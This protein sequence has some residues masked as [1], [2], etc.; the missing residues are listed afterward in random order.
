MAKKSEAAKV[1]TANRLGDGLV[2]FLGKE[3]VW[4]ED[5]GKAKI[6]H[7]GEDADALLQQGINAEK[8]NHVVEPYLIDVGDDEAAVTPLHIRE[9]IRTLGPSVRL[10]LGK[11]AA[12][13]LF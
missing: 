8:S 11:Q 4:V 6:A 3:S 13:H 2:V 1:V 12:E 9:R 10:D 5:I 7:A